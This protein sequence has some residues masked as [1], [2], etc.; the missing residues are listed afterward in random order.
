[1]RVVVGYTDTHV[2]A[3]SLRERARLAGLDASVAQDGCGRLR[4]SVDDVRTMD[5]LYALV[6][7]AQAAGLRPTIEGD[8]DD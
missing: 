4:V 7:E 5:G 2:E 3:S 1:M 8:N 6:A